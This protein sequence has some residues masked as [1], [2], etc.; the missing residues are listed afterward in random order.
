VHQIEQLG[1]LGRLIGA[2]ETL[3]KVPPEQIILRWANYHL[4]NAG[5]H[6]MMTNF[7]EDIKVRNQTI[8]RSIIYQFFLSY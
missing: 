4:K 5:H 8:N 3:A 7:S 1:D 6:R 2:D